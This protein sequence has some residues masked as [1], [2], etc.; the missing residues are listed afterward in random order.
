[1]RIGAVVNF[2]TFP[3]TI[4]WKL[5]C[6][7]CWEATTHMLKMTP[8]LGE[9]YRPDGE[10][11]LWAPL[12]ALMLVAGSGSC[13]D[14][15]CCIYGVISSNDAPM[16]YEAFSQGNFLAPCICTVMTWIA[17]KTPTEERHLTLPCCGSCPKSF[18]VDWLQVWPLFVFEREYADESKKIFLMGTSGIH[19]CQNH[20]AKA[21]R[22]RR[23]YPKLCPPALQSLNTPH[24]HWLNL[25]TRQR[26]SNVWLY[27]FVSGAHQFIILMLMDIWLHSIE[28][29]W[30]FMYKLLSHTFSFFL[31][32]FS[33]MELLCHRIDKCLT[34]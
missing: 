7:Q 32:R 25:T 23:K 28:L 17:A 1:M 4:W 13:W 2:L 10:T 18:W 16:G 26:S 12:S 34:F 31:D 8:G 27:P 21:G 22:G 29:L 30:I 11:I 5:E 6:Q 14:L 24:P 3:P 9:L 33:G 15:G 19:H 20:N